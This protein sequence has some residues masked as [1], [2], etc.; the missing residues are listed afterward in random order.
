M[1]LRHEEVSVEACIIVPRTLRRFL[2]AVW[3][4]DTKVTFCHDFHLLCGQ[5]MTRSTATAAFPARSENARGSHITESAGKWR[6][7]TRDLHVT[8][9]R[10]QHVH[11]NKRTTRWFRI[12]TLVVLCHLW[13]VHFNQLVFMATNHCGQ[14][15]IKS[16]SQAALADSVIFL[17][18]LNKGMPHRTN[19][20]QAWNSTNYFFFLFLAMLLF[21][22]CSA[23]NVKESFGKDSWSSVFLIFWGLLPATEKPNPEAFVSHQT[24]EVFCGKSLDEAG[25]AAH[26]RGMCYYFLFEEEIMQSSMFWNNGNLS[27]QL[28]RPWRS[29]FDAARSP[30]RFL[31]SQL[32]WQFLCSWVIL[33]LTPNVMGAPYSPKTKICQRRTK[34]VSGTDFQIVISSAFHCGRRLT[35]NFQNGPF[36]SQILIEWSLRG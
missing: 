20:L 27:T 18:P 26:F 19:S 32:I 10:L 9:M 17:S 3:D 24:M 13:T 4:H 30:Y 36:A 29:S 6:G 12:C 22:V 5:K 7:F 21:F 33:G 31:H 1:S 14:R 25:W 2:L 16:P 23:N 34:R 8:Q 15:P 35:S 11:T 28:I